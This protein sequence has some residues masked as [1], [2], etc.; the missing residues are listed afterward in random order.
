MSMDELR[1]YEKGMH[2]ATNK[3]VG[4]D[5]VAVD[6]AAPASEPSTPSNTPTDVT[7]PACLS[8]EHTKAL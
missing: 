2:E 5:T 1:D 3:K 6:V 8:N 7:S 4:M